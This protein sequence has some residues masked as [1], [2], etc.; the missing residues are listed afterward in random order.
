MNQTWLGFIN[1]I[2]S[3]KG[4]AL[5]QK[6]F[7]W[8]LWTSSSQFT[9]MVFDK[10]PVALVSLLGLFAGT[11]A[12]TSSACT[13]DAFSSLT[14]NNIEVYSLNV[15]AARSFPISGYL[16]TGGT[17]SIG[18]TPS[19]ADICSITLT[20]THPGKDDKVHTYIGLPLDA[21]NWNSRFL[22]NGGGG[23]TAGG[24]E[25]I[26]S[27][28]ALGYASSSTDGGHNSTTPAAEWGLKAPGKTNWPALQDFASV[29][30]YE[31]ALLGKMATK[32]YYGSTAKYS[33]WNGCSTG[34]RQGH[35]MAQRYPELFDGIV[36]AAP[37][38]NWDRFI[39]AEFWGALMANI[40]GKR[41]PI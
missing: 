10:L 35:M 33:Y 8:S 14:L 2:T 9:N 19:A 36:G 34:G 26:L 5:S 20:Y 17:G 31:A 3:P 21:K 39:V 28:V 24:E 37:A 32:I 41:Y 7:S 40:L 25:M 29:A 15:T 11:R 1:Q 38:I 16:G 18:P 4:G 27:P 30:L 22:M 12:S 13:P 23:W 6:G